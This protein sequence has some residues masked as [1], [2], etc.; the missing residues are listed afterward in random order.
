MP[1]K[2]WHLN[3]AR[4]HAVFP[5]PF[6][7]SCQSICEATTSVRRRRCTSWQRWSTGWSLRRIN[8]ASKIFPRSWRSSS[9]RIRS[10]T[11]P[12][13]TGRGWADISEQQKNL[14]RITGFMAEESNKRRHILVLNQPSEWNVY[15]SL[16]FSCFSLSVHHGAVQQ[17]RG[18]NSRRSK[19]L[20]PQDHLQVAHIRF[21]LL[22]SQ[23]KHVCCCYIFSCCFI[24][25][26]FSLFT[27]SGE[28]STQFFYTSRKSNA[29]CS[30]TLLE[31]KFKHSGFYFHKKAQNY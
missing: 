21:C 13:T 23:G 2:C 31:G 10:D 15:L 12:P 3:S 29:A 22:W 4:R 27:V 18:E 5:L 20:L 25:L 11:C 14:N 7:R 8:Q 9:L 28:R 1:R 30:S 16:I 24:V 6:Y 19:T 26:S 17:A